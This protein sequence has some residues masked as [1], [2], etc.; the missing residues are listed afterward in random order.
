MFF[1]IRGMQHLARINGLLQGLIF[2][3]RMCFFMMLSF[4]AREVNRYLKQP[5][6]WH[7][8]DPITCLPRVYMMHTLWVRQLKEAATIPRIA[9]FLKFFIIQFY[10]SNYEMR[11]TWLQETVTGPIREQSGKGPEPR[12]GNCRLRYIRVVLPYDRPLSLCIKGSSSSFFLFSS[13][14]PSFVIPFRGS[15]SSWSC[16]IFLKHLFNTGD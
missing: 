11:G 15:Q 7:L 9:V 12:S 1:L 10:L 14:L 6:A 4:K 2:F 3:P 8:T 16:I 13:L 5:A